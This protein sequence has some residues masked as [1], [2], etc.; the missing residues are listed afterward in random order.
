MTTTQRTH[1]IP[2]PLCTNDAKTIELFYAKRKEDR[3]TLTEYLLHSSNPRWAAS[4]LIRAIANGLG[5]AAKLDGELQVAVGK[6]NEVANWLACCPGRTPPI[7][8]TAHDLKTEMTGLKQHLEPVIHHFDG[9]YNAWTQ[10]TKRKHIPYAD[11]GR[12]LVSW[13]KRQG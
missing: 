12:W 2:H 7:D 10:K 8:Q 9:S 3:E 1:H 11:A 5:R 13:W 4:H 6:L